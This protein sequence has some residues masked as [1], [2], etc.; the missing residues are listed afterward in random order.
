MFSIVN[1]VVFQSACVVFQSAC[2]VLHIQMEL[3]TQTLW[4][5][6]QERNT[7]VSSTLSSHGKDPQVRGRNT[8]TFLV[9]SRTT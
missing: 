6:L 5:W 2:V 9:V 1:H 7:H 8:P 3:C 4:Q